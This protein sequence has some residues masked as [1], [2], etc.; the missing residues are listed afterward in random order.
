MDPDTS[1]TRAFFGALLALSTIACGAPSF[2]VRF[3]GAVE[4]LSGDDVVCLEWGVHLDEG[5]DEY[6]PIAA[7]P[8]RWGDR[9][10]SAER[11]LADFEARD[12]SELTFVAALWG[13]DSECESPCDGDRDPDVFCP[14]DYAGSATT[15][16]FA[17][18]GELEL[19]LRS[20]AELRASALFRANTLTYHVMPW[21]TGSDR[22]MVGVLGGWATAALGEVTSLGELAFVIPEIVQGQPR[23]ADVTT[24]PDDTE[25]IAFPSTLEIGEAPHR[26]GLPQT[27][28]N[29]VC[30]SAAP[31]G[32]FGP[33]EAIPVEFEMSLAGKIADR[34]YP[35]PHQ[36]AE[37]ARLP[38]DSPISL[39]VDGREPSSVDA[40]LREPDGAV[41]RTVAGRMW[42][43]GLTPRT[44][45]GGVAQAAGAFESSSDEV[46][47]FEPGTLQ[48]GAWAWDGALWQQR[49]GECDPLY[50]CPVRRTG[51][52]VTPGLEPGQ[53]LMLGGFEVGDQGLPLRYL[54]RWGVEGWRRYPAC[55]GSDCPPARGNH[56]MVLAELPA[57]PTLVVFGGDA[58][59][60]IL[61]DTWL[62]DGQ[63]WTEATA[64][65][66]DGCP[67]ARAHHAMAFDEARG[68]L[69]MFGG[70]DGSDR[71]R[72]DTWRWTQSAGWERLDLPPEQSP[73]PRRGHAM[74]YDA[75]RQ[76]VLLYG[77][78]S[79]VDGNYADLWSFADGTW[80]A[81]GRR[82]VG[83][84][85]PAPRTGHTLVYDPAR[86]VVVAFAGASD[87]KVWELGDGPDAR[88]AHLF[89]FAL[90]ASN[91]ATDALDQLEV[92]LVAGADD[93]AGG[94]AGVDLFVWDGHWDRV[95]AQPSSSAAP[96]T[97][98]WTAPFDPAWAVDVDGRGATLTLAVVPTTAEGEDTQL[99]TDHI[100]VR[101]RYVPPKP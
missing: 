65:G 62:F 11:G 38:K 20:A 7:V 17:D 82:C 51:F 88:P 46:W 28:G 87:P 98:S 1:L 50:F 31:F 30:V 41:A 18:K 67:A 34:E 78:A 85:C 71:D 80:S 75:A 32:V 21:A 92:E 8:F 24:R 83:A 100:A 44:G 23:C 69:V 91:L 89:R 5:R 57:G 86:D 76:Q 16:S 36:F 15:S 73:T 48:D 94:A 58:Y 95:Q 64:C 14:P 9:V 61:D 12:G 55:Q 35:N 77:G 70:T 60:G 49:V 56:A 72:G 74:T 33:W 10:S 99:A 25:Q 63:S 37:F 19:S 101:A 96:G 40:D 79:D 47:L 90:W 2:D 93:G 39:S 4:E 13:P 81:Q 84:S 97:L 43:I 68:E 54:W 42:T 53:I 26:E 22:A 29:A 59:G 27:V 66:D 45:P 52:R 3:S 6:E